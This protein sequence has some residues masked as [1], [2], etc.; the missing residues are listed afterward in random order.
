MVF[1]KV[2][3]A[4]TIENTE[5]QTKKIKNQLRSL[6]LGITTASIAM[7]LLLNIS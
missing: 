3:N 2:V 4:L 1:I 5:K 7:S 6:C